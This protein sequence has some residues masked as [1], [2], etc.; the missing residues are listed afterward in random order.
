MN[1]FAAGT[2]WRE[3]D[4]LAPW[5]LLWLMALPLAFWW[6]SRAS[7]NGKI[8]AVA[9]ASAPWLQPTNDLEKGRPSWRLRLRRLPRYLQ[10]LGLVLVIFA[11]ARPVLRERMDREHSGIDILLCLDLSSSMAAKDTAV[12]GDEGLAESKDSELL[13]SSRL[14]ASRLAAIQFVESRRRDRIALLSFARFPDLRC[15][16]TRDHAALI[17]FLKNLKS[18][19]PKSSEDATGIGAA[20]ARGAQALQNSPGPSRVIILLTDGEENVATAETPD[21]IA[22]LHAAQLCQQLG[23][24]VYSIAVGGQMSIDDRA[25]PDHSQIEALAKK[26][27]GRFFA[28]GD[29]TALRAAY[30]A[31]DKLERSE[32]SE[33]KYRY[34]EAFVSFLGLALLALLAGR[35][36][37]QTTLR[38]SP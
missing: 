16:L 11:M 19:D 15:P 2:W 31:I 32:T 21:E 22:P 27:G 1:L 30:A 3:W 12:E 37:G 24:R 33:P 7:Q 20:L 8:P 34:R 23:I 26:S 10:L 28:V 13:I 38:V 6:F 36:L 18:L 25:A 5:Q 35:I 29:L 14:D 17:E 9:F 4:W